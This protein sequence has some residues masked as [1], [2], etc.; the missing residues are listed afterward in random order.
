MGATGSSLVTQALPRKRK[1]WKRIL[2]ISVLILVLLLAAVCGYVYWLVHKSLPVIS[3]RLV[4]D[5]LQQQVSVW[6]DENGVPHIE[7]K[8]ERDLYIAQGYVT[9]QDRLFQM[10]LSR[11]QASGQ[12]SEVIGDVT[13]DRDKF[14]RAFGLRRAAEASWDAYTNEA[15]RMLEWYAQGVND[16]MH[17]SIDSGKLPIEFTIM[18]YKPKDWQP[19]D[20]LTIGKYMAYDLG[21]H[22]QG[23]AFRY[24]LAQHVSEDMAL[25]LFPSYPEG[26]PTIVQAMKDNPVD[27]NRMVA[28]A[29]IPDPFNGSNNWVIGGTKSASGKPMLSNDPHLGL[30]TPSIWYETHLQA[31]GVNVSGVIFAG[32]P[33][34]IV[35]HN[36]HVAWGVT[37]VGPD[38]MDLYIEKR[39]PDRPHEF[40]YKGKWEPAKIYKE[41]IKVKGQP[42]ILYDVEETRHGPIISEFADDHRKDTA[43]ALKWTALE[44]TTELEAIR[45]FAKAYNWDEF[46]QALTYFQAP[47]QNFVFAADD[48]TIAYRANGK[49]PI[50]KKGD[51]LVPVPG[52]TGEYEWTGYIPWE[53]LPTSVNPSK[54]Y[55]A[56]ANNKIIDDSYPYHISNT[57]EQPYREMRIQQYLESKQVL[58]VEDLEKLQFDR[59]DLM[60]EEFLPGLIKAGKNAG[61]LRPIDEKALDLLQS[62]NKVDD[63]E[64]GAPLVFAQWMSHI[65]DVV[66]KPEI[67]DEMMKLFENKAMVRDDL[68]RKALA[69]KPGKWISNKGGMGQVALK[70]FQAAVD[71]VI[72]LQGDD[73][74]K[75]QWGR[76][77]RVDFAHPLAAVK[78]LDLVFNAK[79]RPMGGSRVTVGA[80]GWD[81]Q[82][83]EVTHG[84]AWR[85]V[86]DLASPLKSFNV[87]GPGQSGHLLSQWYHD[88]AEGWATGQYHETSMD[89]DSYR[90]SAHHLELVPK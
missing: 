72:D 44:P 6:R 29:A 36:E 55:I 80:A 73:A 1:K 69:G 31:P 84:G 35:G 9:A 3:G 76:Y 5:G 13:I 25:E 15:K 23:Q 16:Y 63:P 46:K 2:G 90:S 21:G 62:W 8:N 7:A 19:I 59:K 47:A 10:D 11:R 45:R 18:G 75:W 30:S 26:G 86:V 74:A 82:T 41:E 24:E 22:W 52:W 58:T 65:D 43:F 28:A 33:G 12:L 83:G 54:G 89:P 40:E 77:H 51:S 38:V 48:G 32:V 66:F 27:L 85:T 68:I 57:W 71:E 42:S 78:P 50:R 34:I 64:Q 39:N 53:K 67:T 37:N 56:T 49:I 70:S 60:A 4:I 79:S 87:V 81:N 20:S 88:Q 61:S 14:F 17:Q